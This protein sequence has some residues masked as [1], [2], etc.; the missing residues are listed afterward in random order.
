MSTWVCPKCSEAVSTAYQRNL[1][2]M[3]REHKE[4]MCPARSAPPEE[5]FLTK[6]DEK[7]LQ[8]LKVGWK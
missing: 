4:A 5:L 7:L 6:E 1:P 8:E 3:V 2:I